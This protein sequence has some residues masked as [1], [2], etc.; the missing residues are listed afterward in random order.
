MDIVDKV[1]ESVATTGGASINLASGSTPDAGYMVSRAGSE[2]VITSNSSP[3]RTT[4]NWTVRTHTL[5]SGRTGVLG[6]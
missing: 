3:K 2:I 5:V 6:H 1:L 4:R